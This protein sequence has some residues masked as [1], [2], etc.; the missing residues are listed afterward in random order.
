MSDISILISSRYRIAGLER[1]MES[2]MDTAVNASSLEFIIR[3]DY[4]D[5]ETVEDM[6]AFAKHY[7]ASIKILVGKRTGHKGHPA[8]LWEMANLASGV[9]VMDFNDDAYFHPDSRGWDEALMAIRPDKVV[10]F[11]DR[12]PGNEK[13][14]GDDEVANFPIVPGGWWREFGLTQFQYPTDLSVVHM[15]C[16]GGWHHQ[17]SKGWRRHIMPELRIVHEQRYDKLVD[18]D[19]D[20]RTWD[21]IDLKRKIFEQNKQ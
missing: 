8:R 3:A 17:T 5:H 6:I 19:P 10:V 15:L 20:K 18:E 4:D 7:S 2:A 12:E 13:P 14:W 9:W 11:P 1:A 16:Y 21:D